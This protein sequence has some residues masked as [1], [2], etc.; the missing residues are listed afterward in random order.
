MVG[1]LT[2]LEQSNTVRI[3]LN[4][5][6]KRNGSPPAASRPTIKAWWALSFLAS[7]TASQTILMMAALSLALRRETLAETLRVSTVRQ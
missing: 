5:H 6:F 3:T 1:C 4:S 2:G 7:V